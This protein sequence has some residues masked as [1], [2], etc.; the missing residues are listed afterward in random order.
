MRLL[1]L[2]IILLLPAFPVAAVSSDAPDSLEVECP[3]RPVTSAY[4]VEWGGASIANTYLTPLKYSGWNL[5]LNYERMQAM[6]Q[7]PDR[8]VMR[9]NAGL[10]FDRTE[11]P[12]GNAEMWHIRGTFAWGMMYRRNLPGNITVGAGGSLGL[13]LGALY[14][15]RNGNNPVAAEASFTFNATAYATWRT[16]FGRIPLTLR[17]QPTLPLT[18]AFFSPA[19]G[20]LFYEIYL[21]NDKGLVHFAWPG[22]YFSLDN[23][24]TAD[25]HLGATC[26]R[27]GYHGEILSTKVNHITTRM[28][29]N[30]IVVGVS[31]EWLSYNPYKG[32]SRQARIVSALY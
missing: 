13:N 27:V 18:G 2:L 5:G 19:Y 12:V 22:N 30:S 32:L 29:T 1:F 9:L 20:E 28:I 3:L 24:L 14:A 10:K 8:M 17:Y 31:G 25:L 15:P 21:G 11:N 23:L 4:T 7:N 6:K 26:L 16:K